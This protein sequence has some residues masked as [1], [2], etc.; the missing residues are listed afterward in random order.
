MDFGWNEE[1][2]L[3]RKTVLEF[4]RK[5]LNRPDN[6]EIASDG[7]RVLWK[8]CADFGIMGLPFPKQYGGLETDTLSTALALETLGYGFKDAGFLFAVNAQMWSVQMP[9]WRHGNEQ[10]KQ[11]Y[12][13]RLLAGEW[14]GGHAMSEPGSGSDAFAME[15]TATRCG[16]EYVLRGSKTF[17][18]N[19]PHAN[20]FLVFALT[21]R[22]SGWMGIS[23]FLV[24]R[25]S[26]GITV[27]TK[28][29]KMGLSSAPMAE[30]FFDDCHVPLSARLGKEGQGARIFS[31]SMEWERTLILASQVGAMER[32]LEETVNYAQQRMQSHRP[33][34]KFQAV[35]HRIVEMK[36]RLE[37]ARL[38]LYRAAWAKEKG[39]STF[40]E[41]ALAKVHI[42]EAAVQNALDAIQMH[43]GYGY[44]SEGGVEVALRDAIGSRIYSGT[45]EVLRNVI[46]HDLGL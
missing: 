11:F 45:S 1:Q 26:P 30:V 18:T 5:E 7:W 8:K 17:V 19:A 25:N 14:I 23:G 28:I 31:D 32:Q 33:I 40:S 44:T 38:L 46:A 16:E 9:I 34:G 15:T 43:G 42:S 36:L 13:P 4:A 12:L 21:D 20:M 35:S 6:Q 3:L 2:L 24:D 27:G 29:A 41:S 39:H 10:Q 37:T 22:N